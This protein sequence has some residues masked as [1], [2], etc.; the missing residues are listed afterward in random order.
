MK[1][2]KAQL[3][4]YAH[5][6]LSGYNSVPVGALDDAFFQSECRRL[7]GYVPPTPDQVAKQRARLTRVVNKLIKARKAL[8]GPRGGAPKSGEA[9]REYKNLQWNIDHIMGSL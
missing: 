6:Y 2:S 7:S 8:L 5:D 1:F 4:S 9:L 3:T